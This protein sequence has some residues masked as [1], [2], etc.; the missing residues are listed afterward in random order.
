MRLKELERN[1]EQAKAKFD[2]LRNKEQEEQDTLNQAAEAE[3]RKAAV[4][5]GLEDPRYIME[6]DFQD[7][8]EDNKNDDLDL[9]RVNHSKRLF[10]DEYGA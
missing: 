4:D 1:E 2:E 8:D 10:Y 3:E 6:G 5:E 7:G 9:F